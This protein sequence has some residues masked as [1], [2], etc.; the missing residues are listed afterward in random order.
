MFGALDKVA[1]SYCADGVVAVRANSHGE[2][3][4]IVAD[5]VAVDVRLRRDDIIERRHSESAAWGEKEAEVFGVA[6]GR[7][8]KPEGE[9]RFEKTALVGFGFVAL[10]AIPSQLLRE[11]I[12]HHKDVAARMEKLERGHARTASVI[13]VLVEDIDRLA[14]EVKQMK[15]IPA[16][17]K[18]RIGFRL[19]NDG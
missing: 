18:R 5:L 13:E 10:P 2:L 11:M 7:A 17:T 4:L 3:V 9:H 12:A 8:K 1:A 16:A 15:A 19:G 14:G 6:V